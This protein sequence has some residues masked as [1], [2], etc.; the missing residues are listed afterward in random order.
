[1]LE[2]AE[3]GFHLSALEYRQL[4]KQRENFARRMVGLHTDYDLL[5]TP[6]LAS[7]AFAVN[8]EVPPDSEMKR[9]WQWSPF[10]YAFNLSQQPAATVPCGFASNGLP[11]AM[12]LVG[13]KFADALVLRAGRAY[14]RAHPF[15]MPKL[16]ADGKRLQPA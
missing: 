10:T 1:M 3:P 6:Q 11:V 16:G 15:V 9:W 7:T 8:H 14:E 5:V 2:L 12:Q 4:E 13:A